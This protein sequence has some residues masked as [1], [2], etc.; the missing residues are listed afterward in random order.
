MLDQNLI[1]GLVVVAVVVFA[2][3]SYWPKIRSMIP[4]LEGFEDA[5]PQLPTKPMIPA[6]KVQSGGTAGGSKNAGNTKAA[7][8]A[9]NPNVASMPA[10]SAKTTEQFADY[11]STGEELGAVP[12]AGAQ[13]PQ[14]C[15]PRQQLNPVELLPHDGSSAWAAANPVGAGD[16][17]GKNFLSAGAMIGINTV[18]Q[19]LRNANR[20]LRAEPPN[21][22]QCPGPWNCSTIEPDLQRRPIE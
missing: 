2:V 3:Y 19:S 15:Y 9:K 22:Q 16:L 12:M 18:G 17:Q 6:A 21:P 1:V 7:I 5:A 4:G 14:G 20:Q 10:P 8:M 11:A 13:K